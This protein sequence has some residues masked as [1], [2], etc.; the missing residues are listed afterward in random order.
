M[1]ASNWVITSLMVVGGMKG[2]PADWTAIKI[3]AIGGI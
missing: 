3:A 1:M 2:I